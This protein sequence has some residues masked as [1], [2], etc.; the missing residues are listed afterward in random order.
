[1]EKST[2]KVPHTQAMAAL[3]RRDSVIYN[4]QP[5]HLHCI[6]EARHVPSLFQSQDTAGVE[7]MDKCLSR[8]IL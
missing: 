5:Y 8:A 7:M 4:S 1:M 3:R 2:S 6:G